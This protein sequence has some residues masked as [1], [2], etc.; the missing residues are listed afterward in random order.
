VT[1][2]DRRRAPIRFVWLDAVI[3]APIAGATSTTIAVAA[4]LAAHMNRQGVCWP[5]ESTIATEARCSERSARDHV[6]LLE[7]AGLLTVVRRPG[8]SNSY[9]ALSTTPAMVAGVGYP[10]PRQIT[11]RTPAMVAGEPLLEPVN[12]AR[13]P[14]HAREATPSLNG[15][16]RPGCSCSRCHYGSDASVIRTARAR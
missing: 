15:R 16:H 5:S 14:A 1:D 11:A 6:A 13:A 10:Q 9:R 8:A 7:N 2:A 4:I 12:D 3:A